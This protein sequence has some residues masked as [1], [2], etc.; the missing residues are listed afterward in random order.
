M[1]TI[2]FGNSDSQ[3]V[4]IQIIGDHE[5]KTI[6]SEYA[7]ICALSGHRD[8]CFMVIK[9]DDWNY[10]LSPWTAPAAFG[11]DAFGG[12]AEKTLVEIMKELSWLGSKRKIYLGGYS[13]AG[14][15]VLWSAYQTDMFT[16]IAAVSP[17]VW[18]KGFIPYIENHGIR[19]GKV[20]LSLGD[21][22]EKTRNPV[23]SKVGAAIRE[24]KK[25]ISESGIECILEWNPGNH[26]REP[27]HR[28]AKGFAWL[29][30]E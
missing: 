30:K 25:I 1:N 5:Q 16:G 10:T 23:L 19:T 24:C 18:F 12:G 21:R 15:F 8:F 27:D 2:T 20:Y 26:F 7:E 14:L 6:E 28:V 22:E 11:N 13:L 17:S 29:M 9:T 4:L 3:T